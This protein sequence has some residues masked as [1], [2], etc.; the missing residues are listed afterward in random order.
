LN[1]APS[2]FATDAAFFVLTGTPRST[3]ATSV[4]MKNSHA[5]I[6]TIPNIIGTVRI[7][8]VPVPTERHHDIMR[9]SG[10]TDS[11]NAQLKAAGVGPNTG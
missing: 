9:A 11:W 10:R 2:T 1:F 6:P 8:L 3:V 4:T 5:K 7:K